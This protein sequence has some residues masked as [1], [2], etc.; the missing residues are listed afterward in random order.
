VRVQGEVAPAQL[1]DGGD[2]AMLTRIN[3]FIVACSQ[4]W[5]K[6][7]L[8]FLGQFGTMQVLTAI[9]GEFPEAAAGNVP[10]DM[11]NTL[12]PGQIYSQ[13][14]GYTDRAFD[15]Y[16]TFQIVDYFFPLF[17]GLLLATICA[18]SLRMASPGLYA[19]AVN[20]NLFLLLLIPTCFDWLENLNLLCVVTAWPKQVELAA[21]LAV[22]AKMAK[23]GSMGIAFLVTLLLLLWGAYGWVS[24]RARNSAG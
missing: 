4:S 17:A 24:R 3:L 8:I 15:L 12:Q 5:W 7:L 20:R 21:T 14:D 1:S 11:Q 16:A 13:L 22:A 6:F 18:F 10:F 19:T 9:T 23:L 2:Q